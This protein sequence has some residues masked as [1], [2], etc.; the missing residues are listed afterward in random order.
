MI[1][2]LSHRLSVDSSTLK[3]DKVP[4]VNDTINNISWTYIP[5]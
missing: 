4:I 5:K 3:N 2:N 1:Q